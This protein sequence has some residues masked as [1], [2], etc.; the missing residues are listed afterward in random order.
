MSKTRKQSKCGKGKIIRKA[1]TRKSGTKVPAICVKDM[2]KKGKL[3]K[4]AP[5]IGPLRKGGL[6]KY[7]Y[8]VKASETSR[9]KALT[10]AIRKNGAL[11]TYRKLNAISK[12]TRRTSP[13][14]SK[15]FA[16]DRNWVYVK[17]SEDKGSSK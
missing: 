4:G 16:K 2:G 15:T 3:A 7:G 1:F 14:V 10:R 12:L 17:Y 6:S 11:P 8:S 5:R 9:K 13:S